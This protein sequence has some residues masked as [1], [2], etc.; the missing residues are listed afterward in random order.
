MDARIALFD[1]LMAIESMESMDSNVALNKLGQ[2]ID[3]SI[4]LRNI[5][6][7]NRAIELGNQLLKRDLES[8]CEI[9]LNYYLSNAW[10]NKWRIEMQSDEERWK[11][12]LPHVEKQ[13]I[14]LR[15]AMRND[16]FSELEPTRRCQILTNLGN[17]LDT[18]G[19]SVEAI[20]YWNQAISIIPNFGMAIGNRAFGLAFY[21]KS[22]EDDRQYHIFLRH[23]YSGFS[24]SLAI[25]DQEPYALHPEAKRQF[26]QER[27]LIE[28]ELKASHLSVGSEME[29]ASLGDTSEEIEYRTWCLNHTL[30]LNPLNDLGPYPVAARDVMTTP[31]IVVKMD[32]VM[33][34]QGFYNQLKQEYISARYLHYEG[35][36]SSE[37]HFSD[38][39]VL[40]FNTLDYP[41]YSLSVEKLK[42]AF[43]MSY[44]ILDKVAYFLNSYLSL[45]IPEKQVYFRSLWYVSK[46][47][48]QK[49]RS[50]FEFRR[51]WHLRGLFWLSKDL[52]EKSP[53][54]R[55]CLEPDAQELSDIRNYAEH[56]YLKLHDG[57]SPAKK[58][59]K[60]AT[61]WQS[62]ALAFSMKRGEFENKALRLLKMTRASLIYL[63]LAIH[64]EERVRNQ[65]RSKDGSILRMPL[66][67][68][69]DDWK[70]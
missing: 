25:P 2:L 20:E 57:I 61:D 33:H 55:E 11:W 54:F 53:D 70:R 26:E 58:D 69:E 5:E 49:L 21:A 4:D 15:R 10:D 44:S 34:F 16:L 35:I 65:T 66:D 27:K 51:N 67:I 28:H 47:Q 9:L 23:A 59:M 3:L 30:F 12:E 39:N 50:D 41:A 32:E 63:S 6:G 46:G 43:R 56:K 52:F 7:T 18:V 29:D 19:R 60:Q 31:S 42:I 62:D 38:K 17:L 8:S 64:A 37:P 14:H 68:Y 13:I 1:T 40:L 24:K 22:L 36:T 45:S 48:T